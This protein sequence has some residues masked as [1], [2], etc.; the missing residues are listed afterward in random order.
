MMAKSDSGLTQLFDQLAAFERPPIDT[1]HPK[2]SIDFDLRIASNGDWI[3]EGDMIHR[4]KL[5]KLFSTVLALRDGDYYLVTPGVR[6]RIKVDDAPFQAVEMRIDG[7]GKS[8]KIFFRTNMD[9]VVMADA[10]HPIRVHTNPSNQQPV[11]HVVVRDG[12]TAKMTR[13][14]YY[15]LVDHCLQLTD[16]S[17]EIDTVYALSDGAFFPLA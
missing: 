4:H 2:E 3:H 12:L 7:Q 11:P 6:Y 5:V 16:F 9:E 8:Q 1:W 17:S 14:V 10:E 13:P 15:D